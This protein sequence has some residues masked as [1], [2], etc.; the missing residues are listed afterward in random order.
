LGI[1]GFK[2][3]FIL[4]LISSFCFGQDSIPDVIYEKHTE[5]KETFPNRITAR[6]FFVNTSNS[7]T[8]NDRNSDLFFNLN[9]NKQDRIGASVSFRSITISYSFAPDFIAENKDNDNSKLFN[10]GF[11]TYFG[12]HFMQTLD[13]YQ[14][15]GFYLE[16]NDISVYF[17]N[18]KSFKIG[19]ATSYIF[20]E[21]F[22]FR[23]IVSQDEKQLKST[24]SFIP[25]IVYYYTKF[26]VKTEGNLFDSELHSFDIVFAPSYY[27]NFVPT[28]NLFLSAGVSA[29]IGL[30]HSKNKD[31]N[32][33]E[34]DENLTS[35]VTELNFRGSITYDMSNFYIGTHY[36]YLIL[37][38]DTD[39]SSYVND[40]I[41]FFQIFAGYRFK[42]PKK[43]VRKADDVN[44]KMKLKK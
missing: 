5:Y 22:S 35:L 38:H 32:H 27:Y 7:L 19:G 37:N 2:Y 31:N 26:N 10:L 39:R 6:L 44:N 14:E 11:R 28:K 20:N 33:L 23:A 16:N 13:V 24:G 1:K 36:N 8:V 34:E 29:G 9:P 42:A 21:N 17:P 15:K 41:P 3:G 40:E 4:L 30:N 25:R 43:L 12:K 18:F